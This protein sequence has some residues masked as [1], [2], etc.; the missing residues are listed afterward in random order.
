[1]KG[2]P[3]IFTLTAKGKE[4]AKLTVRSFKT[5]NDILYSEHKLLST[6]PLKGLTMSELENRYHKDQYFSST[7]KNKR[8]A[9]SAV[10]RLTR[11]GYLKYR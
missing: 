2:R 9:I 3:R 8:R 5:Y 4:A 11:L 6:V 7:A 10:R 1:M